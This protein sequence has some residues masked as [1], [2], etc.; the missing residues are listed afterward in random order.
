MQLRRDRSS[1]C[2]PKFAIEFGK[3]KLNHRR[4]T[5]RAG[6]GQ[7]T[8]KQFVH[9]P[10]GSCFR[11]PGIFSPPPGVRPSVRRLRAHRV[12]A[13]VCQL[14]ATW[15]R[16]HEG[17]A[18]APFPRPRPGALSIFNV[19]PPKRLDEESRDSEILQMIDDP[20]VLARG[21]VDDCRDQETLAWSISFGD[22][23]HKRLEKNPFRRRPRY[24]GERG[25]RRLRERDTRRQP[26]PRNEIA[27][28][29][30]SSSLVS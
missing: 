19:V 27:S 2:A 6:V 17:G 3:G 26:F 23:P 8:T 15:P 22:L 12:H 9:Q 29:R 30:P 4:T 7:V 21:D 16:L 25:L 10:S 1:I 13:E 20:R 11:R 18:Q 28:G 24:P 14:R 5:G